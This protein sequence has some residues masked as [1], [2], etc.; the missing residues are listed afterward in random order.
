MARVWPGS[1]ATPGGGMTVIDEDD[2]R[3]IPLTD[4][5]DWEHQVERLGGGAFQFELDSALQTGNIEYELQDD[6]IVAPRFTLTGRWDPAALTASP[7]RIRI[8]DVAS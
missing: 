7:H 3:R 6:N 5:H 8:L 4:Y 1:T 2:T